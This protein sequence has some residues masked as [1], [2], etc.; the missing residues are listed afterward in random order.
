[1]LWI[2]NRG[3]LVHVTWRYG[4]DQ[5]NGGG[6]LLQSE[7]SFFIDSRCFDRRCAAHRSRDDGSV[8]KHT[9]VIGDNSALYGSGWNG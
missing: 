5:V 8:G 3:R 6:Q 2:A 1:L 9:T 7:A 4:V